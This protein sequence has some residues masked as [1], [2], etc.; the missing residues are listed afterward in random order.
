MQNEKVTR[1]ERLIHPRK[2]IVATDLNDRERLQPLAV[3]QARASQAQLTL[4]HADLI[5]MLEQGSEPP[6]PMPRESPGEIAEKMLAE[7]AAE[8]CSQGVG[9][10][11]VVRQGLS[12]VEVLREEVARIGADRLIMATHGRGRI[13]Q[14]MLGSV[15]KSL[16]KILGIPIFVAGPNV[17]SAERY[18]VPKRILHPVS[19]TGRYRDTV[20]VVR[21]IAELYGAELILMHVLGADSD[22]NV[23]P[24]GTIGWAK[25]A[26]DVAIEDRA[27]LTVNL[28]THVAF[29]SVTEE[30]LESAER[31]QADWIVL[32][33]REQSR[34]PQLVESTAYKVMAAA[35][36]P[37]LAM[38][39]PQAAA[40][41]GG[42]QVEVPSAI[43]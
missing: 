12:A 3:A 9:C 19:L 20:E 38:H 7:L 17:R 27:S 31:F 18:A 1:Y 14:L 24:R 34:H 23:N 25:H 10:E 22:E 35:K 5:S 43:A 21:G 28:L 11:A 29:G 15:A 4:V 40:T 26:L 8:M 30:V 42:C 32:G 41:Q 16:L 2:I 13:G 39:H 36:V 37:V 6:I 33:L